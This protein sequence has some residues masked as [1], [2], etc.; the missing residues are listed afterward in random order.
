MFVF[1]FDILE[2]MFAYKPPPLH[3]TLRLPM[4]P[5]SSNSLHTHTH[6]HASSLWSML[7]PSSSYL[8][9]LICYSFLLSHL[10]S[11]FVCMQL[12]LILSKVLSVIIFFFYSCSLNLSCCLLCSSICLS[13]VLLQFE[14][15]LGDVVLGPQWKKIHLFFFWA[16]YTRCVHRHSIGAH[17][18]WNQLT[19]F[20]RDKNRIYGQL[21]MCFNNNSNNK[22]RKTSAR[23][24]TSTHTHTPRLANA[25]A[26]AA[27]EKDWW[28]NSWCTHSTT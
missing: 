25:I 1:Y 9:M 11:I 5:P 26:T 27:H 24:K 4:M 17:G 15:L 19:V 16:N 12:F 8:F 10:N 14:E 18:M 7:S 28:Y 21:F 20:D 22:F 13:F 2:W 23:K 3:H 6:T